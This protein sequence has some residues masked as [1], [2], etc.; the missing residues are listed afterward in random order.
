M[1]H[2]SGGHGVYGRL[3]AL[4]EILKRLFSE[5]EAFIASKM[6]VRFVDL[7]GI[8]KRTRIKE[9]ELL[10]MLDTMAGK[11]LVLDFTRKG[12]TLYILSPT[13]FGFFEFAFMRVR[14]DI[15]QKE[16]A[17]YMVEYVHEAPEFVRSIFTGKVQQGRALVHEETVEPQDLPRVLDHERATHIIREARMCAV[18]LCY[19]RH[20]MEHEGKSCGKAMEACTSFNGGADFLVRRGLARRISKEEA[21][22]IFAATRD[23]G[24]V[25]I[26]DNVKKRPAFVCHCCGCCCGML[27]A[28]SRFKIFGAVVTSP[29]LAAI[30][31]DSCA[32]CGLCAKRCPIN[33][34]S[35][36]ETGGRT[37]VAVDDGACLGC[38]VCKPACQVDA[39]RMIPRKEKVL[40]PEDAWQRTV[41]MAIERGKFQN[42]LF[43]DLDRIDHA[44]LRAITRIVIG[45]PPVKKALLAKQVD[46]RF[47]QEL[48]G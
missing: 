7:A 48:V 31:A 4:Y 36:E 10:P 43:D 1:A 12:K 21:Q 42:L 46:S 11:G 41:L 30:D 25:H 13:L 33:A 9:A 19:C 37:K 35:V 18:S 22:D 14:D 3:P 5:K 6:P 2:L 20:V 39:L 23:A 44:V 28:I 29:F 38:G 32:G 15:P 45:L 17:R 47:F 26:V 16:L 40:V 27:S 8:S 34:I 24:L